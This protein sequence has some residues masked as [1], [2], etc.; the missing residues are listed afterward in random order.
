MA[1][2]TKKLWEQGVF[3][4]PPQ[5]YSCRT[6]I[7]GH[8]FF[9]VCYGFC[10]HT[11]TDRLA[12]LGGGAC[13]GGGPREGGMGVVL[14]IFLKQTFI[15]DTASFKMCGIDPSHVKETSV[16]CSLVIN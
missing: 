6:I 2:P 12:P 3:C 13:R 9:L 16:T 8:I 14:F 11:N 5:Y 15:K 10:V 4:P 1:L 7:I